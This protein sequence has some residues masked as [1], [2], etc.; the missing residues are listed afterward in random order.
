M[1]KKALIFIAIIVVLAAGVFVYQTVGRQ[2]SV[3]V[4][5]NSFDECAVAGYPI[6]ESYPRQCR[7]PDGKNFTE[8]TTT[9][10]N[11][12][13]DLIIVDTP[14]A[15]DKVKSPLVVKGKAR[16]NWYFEASFPV[17]I[18]DKNGKVLIQT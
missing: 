17:R 9:P 14:K 1:N 4:T 15:G 16:G 7:T 8:S 11:D 6:M 18:E 12:K 10:Q 3:N 5:I 13:S 2:E